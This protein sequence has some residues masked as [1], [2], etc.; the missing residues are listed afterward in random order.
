MNEKMLDQMSAA[1]GLPKDVALKAPILTLT[2]HTE[3]T[4]EN[5]RGILEYSELKIRIQTACGEICIQGS[6]M[7]IEHYTN[8]EMLVHGR[9]LTIELKS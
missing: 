1:A 8:T 2:G 6:R 5:Y 3:L 9:I 4:V 7:W